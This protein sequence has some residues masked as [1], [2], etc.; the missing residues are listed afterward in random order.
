MTRRT[1][2]ALVQEAV[3]DLHRLEQ[4]ATREALSEYTGLK[5]SIIDD[6]VKSL[7]LDGLVVRVQRGIYEPV[8]QHPPARPISVTMLP[9][10]TTVHDIGDDVMT[11]TPREQRMHSALTAGFGIQASQVEQGQQQARLVTEMA[12]QIRDISKQM[13]QMQQIVIGIVQDGSQH[14]G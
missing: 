9:D 6:R 12:N 4:T 3:E 7:Q 1:N 2:K 11:F 5:L 13:Q 14:S 8:I 10:G